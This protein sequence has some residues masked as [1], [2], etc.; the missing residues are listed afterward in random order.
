MFISNIF[1]YCA[2][3]H[4]HIFLCASL[5]L[6]ILFPYP[7]FVGVLLVFILVFLS[8]RPWFFGFLV[9]LS[10]SERSSSEALKEE[11]EV[12]P[13]C[14][15]SYTGRFQVEPIP[16]LSFVTHYS[17][18]LLFC[19]QA[20]NVGVLCCLVMSGDPSTQLLSAKG[21]VIKPWWYSQESG[22]LF[23][24]QGGDSEGGLADGQ[25]P[26]VS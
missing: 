21:R 17:P 20:L 11:K 19:G 10:L 1:L 16:Y 2:L 18:S 4:A 25:L 9:L 14:S 6:C 13:L 24:H 3:I 8:S 26:C 12:P 15:P 5:C 7:L 22:T 23:R